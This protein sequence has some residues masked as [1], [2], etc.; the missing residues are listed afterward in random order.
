LCHYSFLLNRLGR[1]SEARSAARQSFE[2]GTAFGDHANIA[3][4]VINFAL[5]L[6]DS[7][8]MEDAKFVFEDALSEAR[9]A[10]DHFLE[11]VCL[12][13]LGETAVQMGELDYAEEY[14][15]QGLKLLKS[16]ANRPLVAYTL[17]LQGEVAALKDQWDEALD[18]ERDALEEFLEIQ[19]NQ[20]IASAL[21][22]IALTHVRAGAEPEMFLTLNS[23]AAELRRNI[24]LRIRPE[25]EGT[26]KRI[27]TK[28]TKYVGKT[29]A[30]A[31]IASGREMR[32]SEAVEM[33]LTAD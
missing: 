21:E 20:G 32:I 7:G 19:D 6:L 2:I 28:A 24:N 12:Q 15:S 26:L 31:A 17:L 29:V 1:F 9:T 16:V 30:G 27:T 25:R 33:A 3:R 18:L 22:A 14:L 11:A 23:A 5:T 13:K 10:E 4:S 8:E